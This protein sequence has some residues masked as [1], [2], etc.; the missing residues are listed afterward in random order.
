MKDVT[1]YRKS[2]DKADSSGVYNTAVVQ[3]GRGNDN[4]NARIANVVTDRMEIP[5]N[6]PL[7]VEPYTGKKNIG[8]NRT[9]LT[10]DQ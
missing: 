2:T 1:A 8:H 5:A 9:T 4:T 3:H 10:N 6:N 7:F